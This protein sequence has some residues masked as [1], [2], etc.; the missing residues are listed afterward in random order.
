MGYDWQ[1]ISYS[2]FLMA[3]LHCEQCLHT[4]C[5]EDKLRLKIISQFS[6]IGDNLLS[7]D[8]SNQYISVNVRYE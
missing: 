2:I 6:S 4:C 5:E 7:V 3:V 8:I 1:K